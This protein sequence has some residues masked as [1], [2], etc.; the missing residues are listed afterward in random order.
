MGDSKQAIEP[1]GELL[2]YT[3]GQD[4]VDKPHV[5]SWPPYL[6]ATMAFLLKKSGAYTRVLQNW[7]PRKDWRGEV[8]EAAK[9]WRESCEHLFESGKEDDGVLVDFP[10]LLDANIKYLVSNQAVDIAAIKADPELA[11]AIVTILAISDEAS[12][13]V[14]QLYKD[15][16]KFVANAHFKL[17]GEQT[18]T[19]CIPRSLATVFPKRHTPSGGL[20]LRSM[21]HNLALHVGSDV[22]ATWNIVPS[23]WS[24]DYLN[25]LV[26][27]WPLKIR[28]NQFRP[29]TA[30]SITMPDS[31]GLFDFVVE[32]EEPRSWLKRLL[33]QAKHLMGRID[34]VVFPECSITALQ[35]R[36]LWSL[37]EKEGAFLVAG[38]LK[39]GPD[40][41]NQVWTRFAL[42][43]PFKQD[44]HHRWCLNRSQIEMYGIGAFLDP[45]RNWWEQIAIES[46][47]VN[48]LEFGP[49]M[50]LCCL[51]CEDLARQEPV[52]ELV[53]A[54]GPHLVI[55]LLSDGP[56]LSQRWSGRY[57][58][59]LADD[60][61][62][63]VLT[64]TSLGMTQ[65]A[66]PPPGKEASRCVALWKDAS[67]R[68]EEI[69]LPKDCQGAVLSLRPRAREQWTADGRSCPGPITTYPELVGLHYVSTNGAQ[70][71]DG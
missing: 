33:N 64:V 69:V 40:Y 2:A 21:S 29:S 70:S 47:V 8:T 38:V 13:G 61:G 52:A 58:T 50:S 19:P 1:L 41:S 20:N 55:A 63:S 32:G 57:A 27:P 30:S 71:G 18:L 59:V 49:G 53:R 14:G 3:L 68:T 42:G 62:C 48:F 43:A 56:Q 12:Y 23:G 11:T 37:C 4:W 31:F 60:P 54:V 25:I 5:R 65:L 44:K 36:E 15:A 9:Q 67:G 66:K 46:R 28:P 16:P 7:P 51:V 35:F 26:A 6:F 17:W 22:L 45:S 10:N 24:G 34:G 39:G